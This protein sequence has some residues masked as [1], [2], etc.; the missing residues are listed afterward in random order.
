MWPTSGRVVRSLTCQTSNQRITR[1]SS[2]QVRGKPL[3]PLARNFTL[4][5]LLST[6]WFQEQIQEYFYKLT[7][8]FTIE[9]KCIQYKQL[10]QICKYSN[11]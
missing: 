6:S 2:N 8:F 7:P 3:F 5:S 4:R 9:L 10:I 11:I 1:I